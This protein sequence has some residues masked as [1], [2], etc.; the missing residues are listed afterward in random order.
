VSLEAEYKGNIQ[1]HLLDNYF[2]KHSVVLTLSF[3]TVKI[4]KIITSAT[5]TSA[6]TFGV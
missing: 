2:A 4:F 3:N 1:R 6:L 5:A